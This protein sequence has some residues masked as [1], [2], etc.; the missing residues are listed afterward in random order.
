MTTNTNTDTDTDTN[1]NTDAHGL[2]SRR[3][4]LGRAECAVLQGV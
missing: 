4:D 1:T 3:L 2:P